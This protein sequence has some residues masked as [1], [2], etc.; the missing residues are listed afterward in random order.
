MMFGF[1][2]AGL[3]GTAGLTLDVGQVFV[4]KR[5]FAAATE[6]TALAGAYALSQSNATQATVQAA[7]L[8]DLL[9]TSKCRRLWSVGPLYTLEGRQ[10]QVFTAEIDGAGWFAPLRLVSR[11]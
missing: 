2:A 1:M 4:A 10:N 9:T 7:V 11:F 6:A 8:A 5:N 3:M